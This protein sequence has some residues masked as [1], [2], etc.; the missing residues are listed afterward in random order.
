MCCIQARILF[1][2]YAVVTLYFFIFQEVVEDL[3]EEEEEVSEEEVGEAVG[4]VDSTGMTKD[5]QNR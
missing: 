5:L 1:W 3:G 4:V 2:H